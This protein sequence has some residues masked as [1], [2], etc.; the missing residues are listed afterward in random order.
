MKDCKIEGLVNLGLSIKHCKSLK[1][2]QIEKP[3]QTSITWGF[4]LNWLIMKFG[5]P[6]H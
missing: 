2:Q 6:P 3:Q 4:N 1:S 5:Q